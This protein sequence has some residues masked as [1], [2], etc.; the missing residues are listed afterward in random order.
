MPESV[1]TPEP[2]PV[3]AAIV[4]SELGVLIGRRNDG[5]PPWTFIEGEIEPGNPL[6]TRAYVRSKKTADD[7]SGAV[8]AGSLVPDAYPAE[9]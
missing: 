1:A 9:D 3:V 2:Q 8:L 4:T 7:V 5:K 6:K